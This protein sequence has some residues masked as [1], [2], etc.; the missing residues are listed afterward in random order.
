ML[1]LN[2]IT[3]SSPLALGTAG[4]GTDVPL[5]ASFRLL[6]AYSGAGGNHFDTAHDYASWVPNGIGASEKTIGQWLRRTGMRAQVLIA[7]KAGCTRGEVKRIRRDVLRD[8]ISFSL[9]RLGIDQVDIFWLHRDDPAVPA[10]E[11]LGWLEELRREKRFVAC[12]ASN[13]SSARLAE[14]QTRAATLGVPGFVASQCG[15][16]LAALEANEFATGDARFLQSEDEAWHTRTGFPLVAW[17]S[18]AGGFFSGHYEP[19]IKPASPR[20]HV[21]TLHY[22]NPAN[23]RRLAIAREIAATRRATANQVVLAWLR[24]QKFPVIPVIGPRTQEQLQDSLASV[25]IKLSA[26]EVRRL[27]NPDPEGKVAAT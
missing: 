17:E 10:D 12:G 5:D 20:A 25:S 4:F 21:V 15:W 22:A 24:Q 6:D 7:T 16:N 3:T 23:W 13:W 19:G 26:D 27:R 18:Q 1:S 9:E 11:I 8:E 14:T 2:L